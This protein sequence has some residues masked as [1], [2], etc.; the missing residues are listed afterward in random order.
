MLILPIAAF[1]CCAREASTL[2]RR[3]TVNGLQTYPAWSAEESAKEIATRLTGITKEAST[4]LIRIRTA[5]PPHIHKEHDAVVFI[6]SGTGRVHLNGQ[7]IP[8]KPG[9]VVELPRNIPHWAE[10]TGAD[11][12]TVYAV[13]T[14]PYDGKDRVLLEVRK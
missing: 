5:E 9:D 12:T 11:A 1:L 6:L 2:G 3:I 13:F 4:H 8:Y 7:T 10:N 14:P